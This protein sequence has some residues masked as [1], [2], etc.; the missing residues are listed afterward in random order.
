MTEAELVAGEGAELH[1][2]LDQARAGG[3]TRSWHGLQ[4]RI[5]VLHCHQHAL[6][7]DAG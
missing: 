1:R 2:I 7:V 6:V 4:A 3:K 5:I